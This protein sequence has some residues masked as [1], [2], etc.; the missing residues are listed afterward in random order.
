M[1]TVYVPYSP[2]SSDANAGFDRVLV[3]PGQTAF[4]EG[5]EFRAYKELNIAVSATYVVKVVVAVN[6]VLSSFTF[7]IDAGWLKAA[8]RVGGTPGG[9]FS[10][11][12]TPIAANNMSAGKNHRSDFGAGH[13]SVYSVQNLI[14]AGGTH[15]GGT[16]LDVVRIKCA[17]DSKQSSSVG[18]VL[19]DIRGIAANTYYLVMQNLGTDIITGTLKM[20]WEE[21]P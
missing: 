21:R 2:L 19:F 20:R 14:T 17:G 4:M 15:T 18:N 3:E 10:E 11:T 8:S 12:I 16:E 5:R 9:S 6:T 13:G 1:M 7:D